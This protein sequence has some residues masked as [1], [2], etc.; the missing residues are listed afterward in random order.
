MDNTDRIKIHDESAST[1]DS[2]VK[3]YNSYGHEALF[4]MCFEYV[5]AGDT[6]CDLGIGTGLS[7]INFA[8]AGLDV[9]GMDASAGMLE[10]CR[11]KGFTRELKQHSITDIPLPYADTSFSHVISCGVYHFFGDLRPYVEEAGRLLKENGLFAF[12]IASLTPKDRNS[13][14]ED[15]PQYIEIQ[16]SWGVPIFKHSDPYIYSIARAHEL[17]ILKHQKI[18]VDSG[19]KN[20]DDILFKVIVTRKNGKKNL[21]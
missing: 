3:E 7:S 4:G 15:D 1:Y 13:T 10:E 16:S 5:K 21:L 19:D 20:A 12:T 9:Y 18:L 17:E 6:L 11:K 14:S 8:R 2:Q